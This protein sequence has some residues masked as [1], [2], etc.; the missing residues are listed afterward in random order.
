MVENWPAK[1]LAI[2]FALILFV[3]HR[4]S[5]LETRFLSAPLEVEVSSTLIPANTYTQLVKVNIRG[6]AAGISPIQEGDIEAY[7][8]LTK[9]NAE[10]WYRAPVQ[11]RKKGSA[12]GV[13]PLEISV[14]PL[15][16]SIQLERKISK[17]L[18]LTANLRGTVAPGFDLVFHSF[19]PAQ[20][21]V[22][23][24]LNTLGSVSEL[25]TDFV[26]L[27]GRSEDFSVMVNI[28]KPN[29]AIVIRGNGMA[30]FRGQIRPSVPVRNIEDI[31]IAVVGLDER[32]EADTGGRTG[33]VRLEGDQIQ[34]GLFEPA[35]GFLS[36]DC[37]AV[38]GPGT[39]LLPVEITLPEGLSV[40]RR[41]PEEIGVT[42]APRAAP[43]VDG[44]Q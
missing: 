40:V 18:P 33:S 44:E 32:F 4:M 42:I 16:V 30:E 3:F 41:E 39:Y 21:T 37:S 10:G 19:S 25:F 15:E 8:D 29:P 2:A 35:P 28:L 17:S 27:E 22:D 5:T 9:I 11:I 12:L 34:L 43:P 1:V 24:P 26:N 36:V 13:E 7:I 31:P 6:D 23:G 38:T 14:D 20:V